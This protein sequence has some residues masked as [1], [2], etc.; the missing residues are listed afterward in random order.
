M[1]SEEILRFEC[2]QPQE[3]QARLIMDWRN[4]PHT[5]A[6]S[7]HSAP[8][9]WP[10]FFHEFCEEYFLFPDLPP[11]FVLVEGQ[12]AAF[13]RFRPVSDPENPQRRCCDVSIN[14]APAWRNKGV[15]QRALKQAQ[16]WIA[17][18]GFEAMYAEV[19]SSNTVSLKAFLHA[20]FRQLSD[21]VKILFDTGEQFT[22]SRFIAELGGHAKTN[23]HVFIIAEAGSNWRLGA[24]SRDLAMARTMIQTAAEAGADAVKFQVFRPETIY[25]ANAGSSDYLSEA[26]IKE[27]IRDIFDFLAMPYEMVPELAAECRKCGI[28]FMATPFS[29]ADF[30]AID[31]FVNAHKIASYE[32]GHIHLLE[33][34]AQSGKPIFL[35]T[36]AA[37][38]EDIAWSVNFLKS[39]GAG[40]ITLL[41]CT[42]C[43]PA[44]SV[45]MNL[46][47][48]PWLK[49]RFKV[50]VGL[51]DHSRH[52]VHAPVAA[53]ALGATVIEKHFTIDNRLPGP[54]HAF[55]VT[56]EE[57]KDLVEAVRQAERMRGSWV[58]R[59]DESEYEL[60][61]YACRGIQALHDISPG[62]IFEEDVN[63]SILRPGK[64]QQGVHP[65]YIN[66][67]SGKQ[68]KRAIPA[69]SGLQLGD[70]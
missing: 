49:E 67:I 37:A 38:E 41:Q 42:A 62:E 24:A 44:Q 34:A 46:R 20:G 52:P 9:E 7:Y 64:Q 5:L 29:Q 68:S 30:L 39:R 11:L 36:G 51:S 3:E 17:R 47:S 16:P 66:Q 56:P 54:D 2:V 6:M 59:V 1:P 55:A 45:S 13:L 26:G 57:L 4:D 63:I 10:A 27:D 35:S 8:K 53:V 69:G 15:G 61:A 12:R 22:I 50:E 23:Q 21:A 40:P 70:W 58:K 19:K 48:I 25:V 14:V 43:Y 31:P 65:K 18:Q 60:R 28:Q 33:L 32:L